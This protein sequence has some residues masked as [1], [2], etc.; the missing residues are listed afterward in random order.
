MVQVGGS[1]NTS[2][3]PTADHLQ[4]GPSPDDFED[5]TLPTVGNATRRQ[6]RQVSLSATLPD[7]GT[8]AVRLAPLSQVTAPEASLRT[9]L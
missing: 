5:R 9:Y 8:L 7:A 6:F 4:P 2:R 1:G 3:V